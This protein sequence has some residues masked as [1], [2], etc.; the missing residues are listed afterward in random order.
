MTRALPSIV[1]GPV[2][3]PPWY[4]QRRC[5]GSLLRVQRPPLARWAEQG[6]RWCSEACLDAATFAVISCRLARLLF[7]ISHQT[8][9][10]ARWLECLSAAYLHA[11]LHIINL[12]LTNPPAA[13]SVR[14]LESRR[15]LMLATAFPLRE[16]WPCAPAAGLGLSP[17]LCPALA[18]S[19]FTCRIL[20]MLPSS[21]PP[22]AFLFSIQFAPECFDSPKQAGRGL[23]S[24]HVI[25]WL[26]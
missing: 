7:L 13:H 16:R 2:D 25:S 6:T 11:V 26:Q 21:H 24:V 9:T 15:L 10:R 8:P 14:L 23:V 18:G 4:L 12:P 5:P 17:A 19:P 3:F 1:R 20:H 22:N